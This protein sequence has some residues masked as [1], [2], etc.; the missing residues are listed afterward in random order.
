M[1]YYLDTNI[2]VFFLNNKFPSIKERIMKTPQNDIKIPAVVLGELYYGVAKSDKKEQNLI[3]N[4]RFTSLFE[5][6]AFDDNAARKYGDIR[7]A[8]E[9]SGQIIGG[10][11][12]MIAATTIANGAVLVTNNTNEFSRVDGLIIEDWTKG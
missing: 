5:I 12:M 11:D 1:T 7:A 6:I 4:S 10:N 8:L 2:C 3:R 9:T